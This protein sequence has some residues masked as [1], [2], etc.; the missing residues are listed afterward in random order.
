MRANM[1]DENTLVRQFDFRFASGHDGQPDQEGE[2]VQLN[3]RHEKVAELLAGRLFRIPEYQR[4]YAWGRKQ[5]EDLF[6][7]I[8]EAHR[9]GRDHFMATVVALKRETREIDA[10]EFS[11]VELVDGQQRV[12]T[13]VILLKALE[14]ALSADHKGEARLKRELGELLVKGDD[15][16]LVLLQTNHDSSDIFARYLRTGII[17]RSD[18]ITSSDVNLAEA[19]TECEEFVARWRG[20]LIELASVIRNRLSMI[21]HELSDEATVY[22]VFEVLNSR[23]LDVKWIDKLKSQL[24]SL[25]F[26]HSDSG[27]RTDAVHEMHVLWKDIY[28]TLGKNPELGDEALRF[29]GTWELGLRPNRV[30]SQADAAEQLTINA[31]DSLKT[32]AVTAGKLKRVVEAIHTLHGNVRLRAVTRI[33]HA[34]F[35]AAAIILREFSVDVTQSLTAEWEK[36]TFRIFGLYRADARNKVG[37][38]VRLGYDIVAGQLSAKEIREALIALGS[39]YQIDSVLAWPEIWSNCYE[40]WTEELRYLLYRYDEHLA[41]KSGSRLNQSEWQKVWATDP[42]RSIEHICPQST[43][44]SYVHHLGNLTMLPPNVNSS[45]KDKPPA[46]KAATYRSCGLRATAKVG[47]DL[48]AGM[49]W[50]KAAVLQRAAEIETFVRTEWAD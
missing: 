29:A 23:G 3:P 20:E 49:N 8:G 14:R 2:R 36:T 42:S 9:S 32:I 10:T 25:V 13:L 48:E 12:T 4:A 33:L 5:R 50:D 6:H 11:A 41:Q 26:E 35:V 27:A 1:P 40:G 31:G 16:S 28:R 18:A 15:H 45:L 34:R 24:M 22:R 30:L 19:A 39:D 7:D 17:A 38:Y 43:H 44:R 47:E 46:K 37:D 21:Y